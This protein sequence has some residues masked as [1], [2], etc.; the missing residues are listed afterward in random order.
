MKK[1]HLLLLVLT[2]FF[3]CEEKKEA[4]TEDYHLT[5]KEV[6][7]LDESSSL[8]DSSKEFELNHNKIFQEDLN[9]NSKEYYDKVID[10]FVDEEM[11]FIRLFGEMWDYTFKSQNERN[12]LWKIKIE[13]YFRT[14][15]F[16]S[17][18]RNEVTIYTEG[19]NNQ[20]K[21]GVSKILGVKYSSDIKLNL[22][23]EG[24][25]F[26]TKNETV[27]N[28]VKKINEEIIDQLI[29][30]PLDSFITAII[31]AIIGLIA[32]ISSLT[33]NIISIVVMLCC[34][35]FLFIRSN[36]RQSEM[37]ET[38]QKDVYQVLNNTN[39]N[40]LD[41]LNKNTIEYYSQLEKMN[42]EKSK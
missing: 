16:L 41:Q 1:I 5:K 19:V 18:V 31:I 26:N 20:R 28:I 22:I 34:G 4:S 21:N 29:D 2:I 25:S 35:I 39:I 11:G 13:R 8:I 17:N 12:S 27:E 3:S 32:T 23:V 40:Y 33:K 15:S 30:I 24:N 10:T 36:N 14:T 7:S 38:L 6:I 37:K 42:Y 9:T